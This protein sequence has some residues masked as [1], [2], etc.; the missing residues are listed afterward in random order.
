MT[1]IQTLSIRGMTCASCVRAVERAVARVPGVSQVSVNLATE[2]ARVTFESSVPVSSLTAAVNDAG[3]EADADADETERRAAAARE[4]VRSRAKL[5]VAAGFSLALLYAAMGTMAGFPLPSWVDPMTSP[6]GHALLETLLV[7]PVVITGW[8][9]YTSGFRALIQGH[10]SMD[11]LIALGTSAALLWSAFTTVRAALGQTGSLYYE[12]AAVILTLVQLGKYL[13]TAAKSRT[14]KSLRAL[15]GLAPQTA[16]VVTESGERETVIAEVA[17]GDLVVVRPGQAVPVD[18]E[19]VS[20]VSSV[21]ESMLTGESLP[22]DKQPGGR[23]Y[24][25]TMNGTGTLTVRVTVVGGDTALN[26]IIQLVEDA[27]AAKA[28]LAELADRVSGV[29]VPIVVAIALVAG[30]AWLQAGAGLETAMTVFISVLVIAC[31]CA[32]GLATPT[33]VL[34]GTGAAA[35][36][37]ILIKGGAVLEKARRVTTVVFDKT[38]TLTKGTPEVTGVFPADGF[39]EKGLLI[40]A[41]SAE[42]ASEHP[43]GRAVVALALERGLSLTDSA[44]FTALPGRGVRAKI[45]GREVFVGRDGSD[46]VVNVD[47][48]LA[49]TISWTDTVKETSRAAVT[50]LEARGLKTVLLTGDSK[51]AADRAAAQT[52]IRTVIAEVLPKD[53]AAAVAAL[54]TAGEVVAMVGDGINDAPALAQADVGIALGTGTD[55]AIESADI[56]LMNGDPLAVATVFELSRR[57]VAAI[58]QNL[59]W[60]FGYNVLGIPVAAG[61]LFVFGG[62]LLS[63]AIAAAAMSMSSVSV[64]LN[65]LRLK[66]KSHGLAGRI[67]IEET[68][69]HRHRGAHRDH[70]GTVSHPDL[71]AHDH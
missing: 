59:M 13:E 11:S 25:A 52:G 21:D 34:V 66:G 69:D 71:R 62:P 23:V 57:T 70:G 32:L 1:K 19:V 53:K 28:P 48:R 26:R 51:T 8:R 2:K 29:F 67:G 60:A 3:Y 7:I 33:A 37:G 31:P 41:A 54:Q 63:P 4:Q 22:V 42:R 35:E 55:V 43:L 17:V 49:G 40:L 12:T 30:G 45:G 18:G 14:S 10:P 15:T 65:A 38:G 50:A 20:G 61:L 16:T 24:A 27:Q 44:H 5:A 68:A 47:G 64:L 9:F 39:S 46:V 56:V 6:F 36:R 58:R